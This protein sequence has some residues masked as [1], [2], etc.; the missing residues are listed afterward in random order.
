MHYGCHRKAI[1]CKTTP[2]SS[3]KSLTTEK[4]AQAASIPSLVWAVLLTQ[5]AEPRIEKRTQ[6][7]RYWQ[8]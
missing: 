2:V 3:V 8:C 5:D 4:E 7:S 1:D 6:S